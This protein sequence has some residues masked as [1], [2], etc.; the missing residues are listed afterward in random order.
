[1]AATDAVLARY[2]LRE[3]L[4]PALA[5]THLRPPR[6]QCVVEWRVGCDLCVRCRRRARVSTTCDC[7]PHLSQTNNMAAQREKL[8]MQGT[9]GYPLTALRAL[10]PRTLRRATAPDTVATVECV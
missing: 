3:T 9:T 4:T 8:E 10:T 7:S 1:M 6:P 5:H 2:I